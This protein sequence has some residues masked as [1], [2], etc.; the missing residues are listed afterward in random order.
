M[1]KFAL[2]LIATICAV[3]AMNADDLYIVGQMTGWETGKAQQMTENP[4][5][6][7]TWTGKISANDDFKFLTSRNWAP[8]WIP[9]MDGKGT[10]LQDVTSGETY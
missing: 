5:G 7:Y 3:F 10:N 2:T 9:N 8:C 6:V 4:T 1:K